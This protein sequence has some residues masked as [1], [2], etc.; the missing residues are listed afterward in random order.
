MYDKKLEDNLGGRKCLTE[1]S[2]TL[3][4]KQ[5]KDYQGFVWRIK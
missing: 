1:K 5:E 2:I 3:K 4:Q